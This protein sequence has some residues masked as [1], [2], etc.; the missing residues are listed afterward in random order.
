MFRARLISFWDVCRTEGDEARLHI[1]EGATRYENY[2]ERLIAK[3]CHR[4]GSDGSGG[5]LLWMSTVDPMIVPE[6]SSI[7]QRVTHNAWSG[8]KLIWR[9]LS[10]E[11]A[12]VLNC[13]Q[14]KY[15]MSVAFH[16]STYFLFFFYTASF[17]NV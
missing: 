4:D 5:K 11:Y 3:Y 2:N 16:Q 15:V 6:P 1:R 12:A 14:K 10:C 13:V 8:W 7:R 9:R 17:R